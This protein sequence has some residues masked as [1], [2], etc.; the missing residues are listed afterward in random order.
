M[1]SI[2]EKDFIRAGVAANIRADGRSS[3]DQRTPIVET[4]VLPLVDGSARCRLGEETQV[5]VSVKAEISD[6]DLEQ[7][8][9]KG[10]IVCNV[11]WYFLLSI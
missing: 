11:D 6:A 8:G 2:S 9:D 1:L 7:G 3:V 10:K 5:V 4:G